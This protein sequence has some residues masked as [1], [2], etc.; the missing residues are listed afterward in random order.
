MNHESGENEIDQEFESF[1]GKKTIIPRLGEQHM[2][3]HSPLL[4]TK[5]LS[6]TIYR[7]SPNE[8]VYGKTRESWKELNDR[9]MRLAEGL[10]EIGVKR[11]SKVAVIDFDTHNYLE[12]YYAVP[13]IE[14]ILHTVN[15]R[16]PPEQI[17]YTMSHAEDEVVIVRDEFAPL[18]SKLLPNCKSIKTVIVTSESGS[19]PAGSPPGSIF[20]DDLL[21]RSSGK[22]VPDDFDENTIATLFY[23]S[24]TTGMPKGVWFTHR[25]LVLH[26]LSNA[27]ALSVSQSPVRLEARDVILPLVPMFHVHGWG[28]PYIG[29]LLGQKY[30]LVGK[31][32]PGRILEQMSKEKVTWSHMVPTILNMILN[33]PEINSYREA[34]KHWKVVIGGSALPSELARNA[35]SFGIKIMSGY[36]LSETAPILT[37]GVPGEHEFDLPPE[38]MLHR[39][40]LKTGLPVPLVD[41]RVVDSDMR[42]VPRDDKT[43]GE[44]VVRTPWTT[45]EY[46]KDPAMT[47]ELWAGGWLHT[48][49]LATIDRAGHIKIADRTKDAIKSGG[50]WISTIALEDIII[51]HPSV[52]EAAV[53]GR[54]DEMWGERP[55]AIVALKPGANLE[56]A[57]AKNHFQ[58]YVDS[59]QIAKYWVPD[60]FFFIVEPLPKTSTGKIDKKPLREKYG[61]N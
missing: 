36:G 8:I 37:L 43:I 27:L 6:Q 19:I 7:D 21:Q 52:L 41:L 9:A 53:I 15:I 18:L 12:S 30:V 29:G 3:N 10:K 31:Y 39:S 32:E 42:D 61:R 13:A 17:A 54:H 57:E 26:T 20:Y 58:G 1:P 45:E 55:V 60:N 4:I 48:R 56:E 33:Y 22:F 40:L 16:L 25:Q 47:E 46:Y 24:G 14:G 23:T 28:F 2:R 51:R 49:D 44:I 59:G 11:Q 5:L 34:L 38:E 50:E 35:T